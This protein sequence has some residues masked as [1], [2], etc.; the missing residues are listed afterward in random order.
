VAGREQLIEEIAEPGL[1]HVDLRLGDRHLVGPVIGD[2]PGRRI[3]PRRP[4]YATGRRARIAGRANSARLDG[5][6]QV[7]LARNKQAKKF[8]GTGERGCQMAS[9]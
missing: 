7:R 4:A 9:H 1:E 3:L 8:F 2:V 6:E 5:L